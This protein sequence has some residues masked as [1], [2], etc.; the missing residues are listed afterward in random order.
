[1]TNF[2]L[3]TKV[4]HSESKDAWNVVSKRLGAIY[5]IARIPYTLIGDKKF[6]V[7]E[8]SETLD[9]AKFI[10]KCF[11]YSEEIFKIIGEI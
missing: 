4:V 6:D 7:K 2:N 10:S 5:K 3:E 8:M 11:E 9:Y 1:M